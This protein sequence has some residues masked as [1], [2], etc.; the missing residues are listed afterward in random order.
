MPNIIGSAFGD[1]LNGSAGQDSIFGLG[2]EDS[3]FGLADADLLDGGEGRDTMAGGTGNDRYVVDDV[4]DALVELAGEGDDTL[5][6]TI[7]YVLG[8]GVSIETMTTLYAAGSAAINFTGNEFGQSIYGNAGANWLNGGGGY[9]YL[10][11]LAGNDVY[12][13]DTL[14]DAI[15]EAAGEGDD[16]V[17]SSAGYTLA[18]GVSVETLGTANA[19]STVGLTLIGNE[20]GQSIYGDAGTNFLSGWGGS[21][22]LVGL[23]GNDILE[24]G[25]G[26]DFLSGG[27]GEDIF[28]FSSNDGVDVINDFVSGTDKINLGFLL[29]LQQFSFIGSSAFTGLPGQGR[30]ANGRFE[31]DL[32]G[33]GVPELAVM[34]NG[35]LVAGDFVFLD[36]GIGDW[37][38]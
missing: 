26:N 38:Y 7:S 23:E 5:H 33:D 17:I 25:Q 19:A 29:D 35:S 36:P 20:F 10:V 18:P 1:I 8:A 3:L 16:R 37:D 6:S 11:G 15:L 22:Y 9:D 4:L 21:D 12:V 34:L 30:F 32:D 27:A 14:S 13:V 28:N 31:L 24:G 2:G